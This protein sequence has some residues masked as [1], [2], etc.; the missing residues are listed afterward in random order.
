MAKDYKKIYEE[1]FG[2]SNSPSQLQKNQKSINNLKA[3]L[4]VGGVDPNEALDKRNFIEKKLNLTP[5]Q[6]A[7]FDIFEILNRPQQALFSGIESVQKGEDFSEGAKQGIKGNKKTQFKEIL[8]N[9]GMSD[10][11]GKLDLVDVLGAAGDIFLDPADIIPVAGFSKIN[12]ALDG[13]E[14]LLKAIKSGDSLSDL[15]FKGAGKLVKGTAKGADNLIEKGLSKLDAV[16][17]VK[18]YDNLGNV[19][20][21]TA[22]V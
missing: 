2:K 8:K 14:G 11:E 17:G 13:G 16:K 21:D 1:Q 19:L 20:P 9:Y 3:Q 4:T 6:N 15:A 18:A 22:K 12:K 5:N 7:I 10:R